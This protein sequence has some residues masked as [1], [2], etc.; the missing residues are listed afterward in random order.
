LNQK[1]IL[2]VLPET[3]PGIDNNGGVQ[4]NTQ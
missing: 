2:Y 3:A 4:T 1:L